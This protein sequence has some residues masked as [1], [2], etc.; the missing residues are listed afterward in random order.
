MDSKPIF[1]PGILIITQETSAIYV[2]QFFLSF[3][4]D[5]CLEGIP[6]SFLSNSS[7]PNLVNFRFRF[8]FSLSI[9]LKIFSILGDFSNQS[10]W[11][12]SPLRNSTFTKLFYFL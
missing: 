4:W 1:I 11:D 7:F 12:E 10:Q 2:L 5:G 8:M 9:P 3:L 6:Q